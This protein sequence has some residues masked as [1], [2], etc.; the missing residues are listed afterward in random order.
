MEL[1]SEQLDVI[2]HSIGKHARVLA[3]AGS[4]KSITLA[5]RIKHLAQDQRAPPGSIR[6]LMFNKLA[7]KQFRKHLEQVGLPDVLQ[8][9]VHTFHSFSYKVIRKMTNS[10]VLPE[11]LQFWIGDKKELILLT[12]KR[13]IANLEKEKRIP[14]GFVKPEAALSHI[15]LWKSAL[16]SPE[17]AGCHSSPLMP[18][19]YEEFERLRL[20]KCAL[21]FDDF[22]PLAMELLEGNP[23]ANHQWCHGVRHILVDEYQDINF[24][25]QRLIE[26]LAGRYADVMV[27]GDD[28]QTIY[29]WR[30]ARPTTSF[31][32]SL[33]YSTTSL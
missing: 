20:E 13:A 15:G 28:D 31:M 7:R 26:V 11:L 6:V 1:T 30:G 25:Q 24:G 18:V 22:I 3:V 10:G 12:I 9:E 17:R 33:M 27:V 5:Y 29:E 16:L 14:E 2:N 8:P 23:Y 19:V 4:G 21:T 32:T